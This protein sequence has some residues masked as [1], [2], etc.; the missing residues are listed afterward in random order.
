M[1]ARNKNLH[2]YS[3]STETFLTAAIN[4]YLNLTQAP[5]FL[6]CNNPKS[7]L[8]CVFKILCGDCDIDK[9]VPARPLQGASRTKPDR[10][11]TIP[12]EYCR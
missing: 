2:I 10:I 6:H 11:V 5:V 9:T 4:I 7:Y 3:V 8:K 1:R 12:W